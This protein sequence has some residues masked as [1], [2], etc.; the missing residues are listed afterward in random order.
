M[1]IQDLHTK[2]IE[3]AELAFIQRFRGNLNEAMPLFKE[4]FTYESKAALL[5]L[6]EKI[7]EPSISVLLKSAA[8]LAINCEEF[9]EAER[10]IS[11]GLSGDPPAEIAEEL[12]NLLEE[13][14]FQRHLKLQGVVLEPTDLQLV[15][16]GPGIGYGMAKS[17][18]VLDRI[19]TFEKIALR[20][21]E[22]K[23]GKPF[24]ERGNIPKE[25][26]MNIQPYISVPRAASFAL[27]IRFGGGSKQ[28]Q[29]PGFENSVQIIED[30]VDNITLINQ[31]D[32]NSLKGKITN[33]TYFKNF[34]GLSKELAPDGDEINLVGI[35]ILREG[36]EKTVQFTR[37][38][39]EIKTSEFITG[40][41]SAISKEIHSELIGRLSAADE[42][43]SN[44]RLTLQT[45]IKYFVKVP[46]GLGDIV[47]KYWG[48]Q[49]KISGI[50]IRKNV[51]ELRDIDPA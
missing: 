4:A 39:K 46:E 19:H 33:D 2:A 40:E 36:V 51:I 24:R 45:G 48:E 17:D 42:D 26:R 29:I 5:S 12:R 50:E 15:F 10:H 44:I 31:G 3:F 27:T 21:I 32:Y 22:R 16:A 6:H 9:R 49:V 30:V 35:T 38:R 43:K 7:G 23:S 20:T 28:L 11:I 13:L 47:K 25:I 1:T 37:K 18:D 41:E 8:S 34:I 14:H